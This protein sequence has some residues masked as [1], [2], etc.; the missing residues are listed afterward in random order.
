MDP[1]DGIGNGPMEY[2]RFRDQYPRVRIIRD[3]FKKDSPYLSGEKF[4][5]IFSVSVLE[6]IPTNELAALFDGINQF[7]KP[8]GASIHC[9]DDVVEG[10]T[11]DWHFQEV[12]EALSLQHQLQNRAISPIDA[13][14]YSANVLKDLCDQLRY[15]VDTYY[16]SPLEYYRW[17]GGST[18]EDYPFRKIVSVQ[19]Y[20]TKQ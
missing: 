7:L 19:T 20:I 13:R 3:Y 17:K 5:C 6:H 18:Y 10:P 15:D 9:I 12:A 4:N 16:I 1:Y 14:S 11:S 8:G 2:Q